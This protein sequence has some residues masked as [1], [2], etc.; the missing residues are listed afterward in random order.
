MVVDLADFTD[1]HDFVPVAPTDGLV[2]FLPL[3]LT[4]SKPSAIPA[5]MIRQLGWP[6]DGPDPDLHFIL[7]AISVSWA[8][9]DALRR[10][11]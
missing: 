1:F 11:V 8:T 4:T 6:N 7:A 2:S 10:M 9:C 5:T 3:F